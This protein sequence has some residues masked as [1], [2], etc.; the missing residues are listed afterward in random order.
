MGCHAAMEIISLCAG[1]A[2]S[3][4]NQPFAQKT[5]AVHAARSCSITACMRVDGMAALAP[6]DTTQHLHDLLLPLRGRDG[7]KSSARSMEDSRHGIVPPDP[8]AAW[9]GTSRVPQAPLARLAAWSPGR[10]TQGAL[11]LG[12]T[13]AALHGTSPSTPE[14]TRATQIRELHQKDEGGEVLRRTSA[15]Y[16]VRPA[17]MMFALQISRRQ[18]ARTSRRTC[19]RMRRTNFV[20]AAL[21]LSSCFCWISC[22]SCHSWRSSSACSVLIWPT[23]RRIS[24]NAPPSGPQRSMDAG[25][26]AA[27]ACTNARSSDSRARWG[28][29][30]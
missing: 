21:T 15:S 10:P 19:M 28:S 26:T 4:G 11:A 23:M 8:V 13:C 16:C 1:A 9:K 2:G 12:Q 6:G 3:T 22:R 5:G 17:P 27:R 30:C 20:R 24:T 18:S 25:R 14:G 29:A 7:M